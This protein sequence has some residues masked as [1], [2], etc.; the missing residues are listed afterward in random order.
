MA[1]TTDR[2][3]MQSVRLRVPGFNFDRYADLK[4]L[5]PPSLERSKEMADFSARSLIPPL[6]AADNTDPGLL[7]PFKQPSRFVR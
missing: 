1:Y 2:S 4:S 3:R 7:D 6:H 5:F